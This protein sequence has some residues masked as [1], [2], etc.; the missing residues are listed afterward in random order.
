MHQVWLNILCVLETPLA[1]MQPLDFLPNELLSVVRRIPGLEQ[2]LA[3]YDALDVAQG[4]CGRLGRR[5]E[6]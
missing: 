5:V 3:K 1:D 6:V 4:R 2:R